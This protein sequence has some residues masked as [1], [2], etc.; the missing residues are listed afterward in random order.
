MPGQN[1]HTDGQK[2]AFA[3]YIT[4]GSLGR[5]EGFLAALVSISDPDNHSTPGCSRDV[6]YHLLVIHT[7][8]E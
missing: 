6:R 8:G 3:E 1:G 4:T 2:G 5:F 7:P